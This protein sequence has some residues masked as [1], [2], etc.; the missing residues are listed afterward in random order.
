[1]TWGAGSRVLCPVTQQLP[2]AGAAAP[3]IASPAGTGPGRA[4]TPTREPP[5]WERGRFHNLTSKFWRFNDQ[6]LLKHKIRRRAAC[7]ASVCSMHPMLFLMGRYQ[8]TW[9]LLQSR[10]GE[11]LA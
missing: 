6:E 3:G 9:E 10:D 4:A 1:M 5:A 8:K 2:T 7:K 11:V